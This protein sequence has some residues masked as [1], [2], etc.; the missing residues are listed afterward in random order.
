MMRQVHIILAVLCLAVAQTLGMVWKS[1]SCSHGVGVDKTSPPDRRPQHPN[2]PN[3]QQISPMFVTSDPKWS[4]ARTLAQPCGLTFLFSRNK[5]PPHQAPCTCQRSDHSHALPLAQTSNVWATKDSKMHQK[6]KICI[7]SFRV[8]TC[9]GTFETKAR[10]KS[11]LPFSSVL[12]NG[13]SFSR[14]HRESLSSISPSSRF[15]A[16]NRLPRKT[17]QTIQQTL[18]GI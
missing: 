13:S 1:T 2:T 11:I 9:V 8:L 12:Y 3:G 14:I 4:T 16:W 10:L 5:Q 18:P 17:Q 15:K 7:C 6:R